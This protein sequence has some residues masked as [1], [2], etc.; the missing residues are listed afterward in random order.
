MPR[1]SIGIAA[2]FFEEHNAMPGFLEMATSIADD[3]FLADCGMGGKPSADG[4]LDIIRK[5]GIK[6]VPQWD[7]ADGFG[8]VRSRL[9]EQCPTD[10]VIILDIDERILKTSLIMTCRGEERYPAIANPNLTVNVSGIYDHFGMVV[11]AICAAERQGVKAVRFQ[12]RHWFDFS[13]TRPCE[14]WNIHKDY[15]LRCMKARSGVG[16]T[17][18]PKMHEQAF[19]S[20]LGRSPDHISDDDKLGPF[21]DH[22]HMHFKAMEPEQRKADIRAYDALCQTTSET[23]DLRLMV[24]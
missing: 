13:F 4:T 16:Y 24:T 1:P 9:I 7:L 20:A 3:V 11:D 8:D 12:R 18:F 6:D 21:I 5:W 17:K 2:T 23:N 10:W 14:N 22:F 19:D 15:Q